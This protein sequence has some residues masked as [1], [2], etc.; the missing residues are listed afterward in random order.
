[1]LELEFK[2]YREHQEE[3]VKKYNGKVLVIKGQEVI[4]TF[5]SEIEALTETSKKHQIGT[6]LVHK[7]GSGEDNITMTFHSRVQF[8]K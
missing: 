3:F 5:D 1:M 7:C 6:F 4:G 8:A 2:Y